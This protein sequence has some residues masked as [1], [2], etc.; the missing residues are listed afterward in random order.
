MRNFLSRDILRE[1]SGCLS[2]KT[3]PFITAFAD[4]LETALFL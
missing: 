1:V 3:L 4:E 2:E